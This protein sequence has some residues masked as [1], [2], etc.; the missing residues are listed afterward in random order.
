M[1][2]STAYDPLD[3][4]LDIIH[5][6]IFHD[7]FCQFIAVSVIL[8]CSTSLAQENHQ[9]SP[10]V[11]QVNPSETVILEQIIQLK[12]GHLVS[13]C[14]AWITTQQIFFKCEQLDPDLCK[15][16]AH[17]ER[18]DDCI[19][20]YWKEGVASEWQPGATQGI[21]YRCSFE[22][23]VKYL[24]DSIDCQPTSVYFLNQL[25]NGIPDGA[26]HTGLPKG[27]PNTANLPDVEVTVRGREGWVTEMTLRDP[28]MGNDFFVVKTPWPQVK[29]GT[30]IPGEIDNIEFKEAADPLPNR[31]QFPSGG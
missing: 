10:H 12:E 21:R 20:I 24:L 31:M 8:I 22:E 16:L 19:N 5:K 14:K 25:K 9:L 26:Y 1:L 23:V 30:V 18:D 28:S 15:E 2:F 7:P 27:N 3:L 6:M 17:K 13:I 29:E 4:A 11:L